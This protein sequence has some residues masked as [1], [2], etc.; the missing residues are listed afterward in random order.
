[1]LSNYCTGLTISV[2][3]YA[4]QSLQPIY[5]YR[6]KDNEVTYM[7]T[8]IYIYTYAYI[9]NYYFKYLYII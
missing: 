4:V 1:M 9:Y 5:L 3:G 2:L 7:N 8:A 6:N